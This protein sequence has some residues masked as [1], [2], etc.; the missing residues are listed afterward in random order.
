M[1]TKTLFLF[2]CSIFRL[3]ISA[4]YFSQILRYSLPTLADMI[5]LGPINRNIVDHLINWTI[6]YRNDVRFRIYNIYSICNLVYG[7]TRRKTSYTNI[8]YY[9]VG[10]TFY[11]WYDVK[12][13]MTYILFVF[14]LT[15]ILWKYHPAQ[16]Y[17]SH[18]WNQL[19]R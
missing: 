1:L 16:Q 12:P 3:Q 11:Y 9:F 15:T 8:G 7:Q 19:W 4:Q 10:Y 14:V 18:C 5:V 13:W 17:L 2:N 6:Y